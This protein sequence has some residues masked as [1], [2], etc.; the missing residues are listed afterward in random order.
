MKNR[1]N[2]EK[3]PYISEMKSFT[4]YKIYDIRYTYK[5]LLVLAHHYLEDLLNSIFPVQQIVRA[6]FKNIYRVIY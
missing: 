5:K 6:I 2:S 3:P 4:Y 1:C